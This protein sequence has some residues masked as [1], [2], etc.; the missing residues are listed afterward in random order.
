[1]H[2]IPAYEAEIIAACHAWL[3]NV[4]KTLFTVGPLVPPRTLGRTHQGGPSA[5]DKDTQAISF[6]DAA[7]ERH[8]SETVFYVSFAE[9]KLYKSYDALCH[10]RS[11]LAACTGPPSQSTYGRG[12]RA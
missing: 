2:S 8:G 7:L 9:R 12:W 6:L 1:M 3:E 11:R 10:T 5:P 4:G